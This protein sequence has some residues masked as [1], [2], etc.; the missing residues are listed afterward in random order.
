MFPP[1]SFVPT[2][3][4]KPTQGGIFG[5]ANTGGMFGQATNPNSIIVNK[6]N[7]PAPAP[8]PNVFSAYSGSIPQTASDYDTIM[9]N[10]QDLYSKAGSIQ[11]PNVT[12]GT[13]QAVKPDYT[14]T[15]DVK[16]S[17]A[18]L[19]NI[20]QTGG[21]AP[22]D[23]E[24]IRARSIS[25]IRSIYANAQRELQRSRALQGGYSPGFATAQARMARE[26]ADQIAEKTTAAEAGIGEMVQRGKLTGAQGYAGAASG[27]AGRLAGIAESAAG[28]QN[29]MTQFNLANKLRSDEL[30]RSSLF[31]PWNQQLEA[32]RGMQGLYGTTPALANTFGNQALNAANLGERQRQF[33]TN[34]QYNQLNDIAGAVLGAR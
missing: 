25:P 4:K 29:A 30:N 18:N 7:T 9:K 23:L 3:N 16:A 6:P 28:G 13:G 15:P 17:T 14:T 5:S 22:G 12:A 21:F 19:A 1:S 32:T 33:D 8:K 27:E 11:L 24:N 31:L 20:A 34:Y 2:E 26:M 10:F